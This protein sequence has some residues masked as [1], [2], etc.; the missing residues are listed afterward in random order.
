MKTVSVHEAKTH[1]SALIEKAVVEGEAFIISKSGRPMV[2][3]TRVD[4]PTKKK[5]T[6]FLIGQ[7]RVPD[8]FDAMAAEQIAAS[9]EGTL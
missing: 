4:A 6:G 9:F 2:R 8:D 3:V 1:L 7:M 5:R